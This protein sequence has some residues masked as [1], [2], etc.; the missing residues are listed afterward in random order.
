MNQAMH[1][2]VPPALT[3]PVPRYTSY[4]TANHMRRDVDHAAHASFLAAANAAGPQRP[5]SFYL[6]LP[7]CP[8]LCHY[9]GC[10]VIV[11]RKQG[12]MQRYGDL[13]DDE[14]RLVARALPDRRR[15]GQLR[16]EGH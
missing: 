16:Q 15:V 14:I 4:P 2:D 5:L 8:S 11:T 9:C 7:F 10:H 13:I 12:K 6:H 1:P 3:G